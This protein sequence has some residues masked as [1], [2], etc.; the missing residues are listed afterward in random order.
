MFL[1]NHLKTT[2]MA[3]DTETKKKRGEVNYKTHEEA[4]RVDL[5]LCSFL[6]TSVLSCRDSA[7]MHP[8]TLTSGVLH[9]DACF[10]DW[11]PRSTSENLSRC[12]QPQTKPPLD[13]P[14][15]TRLC[16]SDESTAWF[17]EAIRTCKN[18]RKKK[19]KPQHKLFCLLSGCGWNIIS[20][21]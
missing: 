14:P 11:H 7:L 12:V 21:A 3:S 6:S 5:P 10:C 19:K 18:P 1:H 8:V 4:I 2:L 16:F 13:D 15:P 9:L 17:M 20:R